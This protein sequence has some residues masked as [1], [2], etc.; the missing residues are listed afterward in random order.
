MLKV[1]EDIRR[2]RRSLKE[3][4]DWLGVQ[5]ADPYS[6]EFAVLT[7]TSTL[8][9]DNTSP[10]ARKRLEILSRKKTTAKLAYEEA[11]LEV[12]TEK[13][14]VS[15]EKGRLKLEKMNWAKE[16]LRQQQQEFATWSQHKRQWS[17]AAEPN[18]GPIAQ[19]AKSY[20]QANSEYG[21][22]PDSRHWL[23]VDHRL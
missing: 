14:M 7:H 5:G 18:L 1:K 20:K 10:S 2:H 15:V 23:I 17:S 21:A 3:S 11:K 22:I 6:G 12:E 13:E 19:S 16:E 9:T 4:G 8:S